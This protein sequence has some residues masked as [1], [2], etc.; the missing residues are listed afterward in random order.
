[1]RKRTQIFHILFFI[2]PITFF[3]LLFTLFPMIMNVWLSFTRWDGF[4]QPTF[5]GTENYER[6]AVDPDFWLSFWNTVK[7]VAFIVPLV[8]FLPLLLAI[9]FNQDFKFN[10]VFKAILI[11]PFV[12]SMVVVG[13]LWR[14]MYHP[15]AGPFPPLRALDVLGHYETALYGV[16]FVAFW[17]AMGF[18]MYMFLAGLGSIPPTL[19]E[20]AKIDG[21]GPFQIF[22]YITLPS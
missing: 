5:I 21:A 17:Q 19:Y 12:P 15:Y 10:N 13:V 11:F 18:Y 3:I 6:L 20:A 2:G 9:V 8:T 7:Y 14:W 22:R 16:A 4:A 1:M